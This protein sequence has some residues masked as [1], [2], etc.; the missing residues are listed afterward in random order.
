[1][2][3]VVG[4]P[5][6]GSSG[7]SP[8]GR[9]V[10]P[11][12]GPSTASGRQVDPASFGAVG[13]GRTDDTQALQ[14]ALDSLAAGETLAVAAG[15]RYRHT[16][17]LRIRKA[18]T[19]VSGPGTLLATTE[20]ASS[21]WIEA[22]R[23]TLDGGLVLKMA[24]TS[25]R[26]DAYEQMKLRLAGHSGAVLDHVTI[27]G[28]AAA[29]IYIG[30][31]DHFTVTDVTVR[32][33][34]ADGIHMTEGAHDGTVTRPN[35][36][37][38]GDDGVAVVSYASNPNPDRHITV[39]SPTV[40]SNTWGRG[41][42]VVGGEDITFRNINVVS[43][44]AAAVYVAVEGAPYN[45][46][47]AKRVRV[48]GGTITRANTNASIDHG[49]VLVYSG[50][51]GYTIDDV[52]IDRLRIADTRDSASHQIGV[53]G[54]GGFSNI[55]L[56]GLTITGGPT[57]VLHSQAGRALTASGWTVNGTPYPT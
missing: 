30:G 10:D 15:K 49:A 17:V 50:R 14:K 18:G 25:K 32:D 45:T 12:S 22:D 36:S 38:V 35:V 19:R 7:P 28:S 54:P 57:N 5:A 11:S 24:A 31:A 34:R 13:D 33:T 39:D 27:D 23:V 29:G 42:T 48:L 9:Q 37:G 6:P 20:A 1:V 41:V 56:T 3:S 40:Q 21:V 51:P 26:W 46:A 47:A 2:V 43:S 44:N 52:L 55:R 4:Q 16:A 8:S 53:I